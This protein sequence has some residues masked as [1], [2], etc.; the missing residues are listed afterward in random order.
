MKVL[1]AGLKY[2]YGILERGPSLESKSLVPAIE[3]VSEQSD[4]FWFEENGF[5]DNLNLLQTKLIEYVDTVQPDVVFFVL[6]KDEIYQSTLKYLSNRYIVTNWFC[7]D[8]WRFDDF[9]RVIS[10]FLTVSITNDKYSLKKYEKIGCTSILTQWATLDYEEDLDFSNIDYHYDISFIGSKNPARAWMVNELKKQNINVRCFGAGWKGGRVSFEEMKDVFYKS[11]IN[12]NLSNSVP[13]NFAFLKFAFF[14]FFKACF[15]FKAGS[16]KQYL[17]NG[18]TYFQAIKFYFFGNKTS[19]QV[20]ARNFEIAG[21]G[22]FQ[23]TQ[24]ALEIEDYYNIGT[25]IAIFTNPNEL[26]QQC[27]YYLENDD[28]RKQICKKGHKRTSEYTYV[29]RLREIVDYLKG[30]N[31]ESSEN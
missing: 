25:E 17:R 3:A 4:V 6:M 31:G 5:P 8:T 2:D 18:N 22:G 21:W 20:K 13:Q 9:S 29:A 19:E 27:K 23:L 12:L 26:V 14:N 28:I 11:K 30:I 7:D 24:Y 15:N 16:L 10:P 1:F